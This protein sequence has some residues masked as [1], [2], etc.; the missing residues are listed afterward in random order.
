MAFMFWAIIGILATLT[1]GMML[2]AISEY[3]SKDI[4]RRV[5]LNR[6][7]KIIII[8]LVVFI[9]LVGLL[10]FVFFF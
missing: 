8:A 7:K 1:I 9:I 4:E 6:A 5:R 10:S 3:C 2:V